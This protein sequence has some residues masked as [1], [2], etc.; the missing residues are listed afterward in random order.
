[1]IVKCQANNFFF[2]VFFMQMKSTLSFQIKTN[3]ICDDK[4][5]ERQVFAS[6]VESTLAVLNRSSTD[7][8]NCIAISLEYGN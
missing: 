6:V 1:M 4:S 3:K 8:L 2:L 7:S 5:N